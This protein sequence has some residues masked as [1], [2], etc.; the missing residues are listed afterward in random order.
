MSRSKLL[1][2]EGFVQLC[3]KNGDFLSE[4]K[5]ISEANQ[6]GRWHMA[7]HVLVADTS[8]GMLLAQKRSPFVKIHPSRVEL[9]VGGAV[10]Y[11]E[12]LQAAC[13]REL[14]E[15]VGI[16]ATPKDFQFLFQSKYNHHLTRLSLHTKVV[17]YNYL[18][19]IPKSSEFH[20]HDHETMKALFIESRT[21]HR[22]IAGEVIPRLGR[23][24]P[25]YAYYRRLLQSAEP[26]ITAASCR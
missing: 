9:S 13:A 2:D 7:I 17:L 16:K 3:T 4:R 22:L 21:A 1:V 19:L 23:L 14:F 5:T 8:T 20:F 6:Q 26:F 25:Q 18:L 15:E 10:S 11:G 12:S 24:S